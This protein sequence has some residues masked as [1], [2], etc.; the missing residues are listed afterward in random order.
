MVH[1][2]LSKIK[3]LQSKIELALT[4]SDFKTLAILSTELENSV[5]KLIEEPGYKNNITQQEL[6][7]LHNLL[8]FETIRKKLLLSLR[9]ILWIFHERGKCIKHISNDMFIF[10]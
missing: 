6:A 7:D 4:E 8:A 10:Y 2:Y 1:D 5:E 9:P 3:S